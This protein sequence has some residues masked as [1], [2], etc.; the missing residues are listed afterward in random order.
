MSNKEQENPLIS[1]LVNVIIPVL[2]LSYLSKDP[3]FQR[4]IGE[5]PRIWHIGP[6]WSMILAIML[7]V[8]YGIYDL[9]LRRKF[10]YFSILGIIGVLLTGGIT[11]MV[12]GKDGSIHQNTPQFFGL[13]EAA[14]PFIFALAIFG[15]HWT[16]AP[17]IKVFLYNPD[18]F[19]IPTIEKKV[20]ENQQEHA[21]RRVIFFATL[22]MT[23]SFLIST[24]ANFFLALYFLKP[25]LALEN[26]QQ[27]VAY[28][29]AVGKLLGWGFA[30]IG[31]PMLVLIFAT[32]FLLVKKLKHITG[33]KNAEQLFLPR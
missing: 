16:K 4:S 27:L 3:E 25:V 21:Y 6:V 14:I 32:T 12:V 7:P 17:L 5:E 22:M 26:S 9:V 19:D 28:N 15:S 11:L 13:K 10:N 33:L 29:E 24:V 1:I 20:A 30:V 18:I 23:G 8:G 31:I 2:A